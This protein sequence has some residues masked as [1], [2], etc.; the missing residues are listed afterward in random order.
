MTCNMGEV[1]SLK[2]SFRDVSL[3]LHT[4]SRQISFSIISSVQK[5]SGLEREPVFLVL[6]KSASS[7]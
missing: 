7:I 3:S 1:N 6:G 4:S 2:G 5:I